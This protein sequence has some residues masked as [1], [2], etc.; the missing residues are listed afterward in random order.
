MRN[1]PGLA[2]ISGT[3]FILILAGCGTK[4]T[5]DDPMVQLASLKEQKSAIDAKISDLEKQLEAKGLI[6]KKLHTV[7]LKEIA[8]APFRHYIDLQ[9]R[10]DASESVAATS[11]IPGAL[12]KV[13]I[14]NGDYVKSGQLMAEIEDAVLQKN[15][16]ELEGQLAVATDLYN[17]QKSLWDQNIGSEVQY[18]QAKNNKE[19]LERSMATLKENM[20]MTKIYA[21]TSGTVDMVMIGRPL[22]S[23]P[24]W[25]YAAARKLGVEKP[26]W[27]LPAPYAHWLERYRN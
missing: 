10:V 18:I 11:K 27:V 24:H 21:P 26:S 3:V 25:P 22:L 8:Y 6:Q 16:A 23:N 4:Q 19:S 14:E 9:G 13:Y 17:R 5:S 20:A 2:F 1:F 7:G 12:K 15:M